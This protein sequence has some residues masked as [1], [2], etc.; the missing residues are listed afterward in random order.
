MHA[1]FYAPDADGPDALVSL[2]ADEALHLTRVLRLRTGDEVRVFNGKGSEFEAVVEGATRGGVTVRTRARRDALV[3]P[4][5]AV[6]LA[7]AVLKADKMDDVVRD[8]VMLGVSTVQ[9]LVTQRSEV[10]A[11]AIERGRRRERWTRVAVSSAKQC[12]RAVVP[13]V[14]AP[15][16]FDDLLSALAGLELP[17]PALL[18]TEPGA[19]DEARSIAELRLDP[20][21]NATLIVGPEGGWTPHELEHAS[22]SCSLVTLGQRTLRADAAAL[23]ALSA[24]FAIWKEF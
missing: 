22:S 14:R 10:T 7:Q 2:P 21:A 17:S 5:I 8:A 15:V 13:D 19:S 23:V 1:R 12:G 4:R 11:A 16:A 6:T 24:L 3:E 18:L 20:P 9:P